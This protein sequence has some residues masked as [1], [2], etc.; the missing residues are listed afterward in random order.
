M[1]EL[2]SSLCSLFGPSGHEDKVRNFIIEEI[3]EIAD[4]YFIDKL[5]NLIVVKK[6]GAK[7]IMLAAHM[8]EIGLIITHIDNKGFLRFANIGGQNIY[9]LLGHKV[10]FENGTVGCIHMEEKAEV[11]N[12]KMDNLYIDIGAST[13][14]EVRE[15]VGIGDMATMMGYTDYLGTRI[16]S[17]SMDD[18][19]GCAV[20]IEVLKKLTK[21]T[22]TIYAVFTVQEEVGLRGA[23]TAAFHIDPDLGIAIDV[24]ATG[25]T[26]ES[27]TMAVELGKGPAIKIKDNSMIVHH[28]VKRLLENSAKNGNINYQYEVLEYGGTDSGAIHITKEGVPSG[29]ISIPCRYVHSSSEMIDFNDVKGAVDLLLIAIKEPL[30]LYGL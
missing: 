12:L 4:D 5:G 8:D 30:E 9:R 21:P 27:R 15:K 10:V 1:K 17:K 23:K 22:H 3:K 18:R 16:I 24:T 6:G 19:I 7:K 25:D 2:I 14:E 28:G 20:L 29:V 13:L 11:K 26:P